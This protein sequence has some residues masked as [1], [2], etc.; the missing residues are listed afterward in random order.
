DGNIWLT[1]ADGVKSYQLTT[2]G[3]YFSPS[4]ADNG[5]IVAG[6][7]STIV[8]MD[9]AGRLLGPPVPVV[10]GDTTTG[11]PSPADKFYGPMD[12]KVSPDGKQVAYWFWEYTN[13]YSAT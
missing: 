11:G 10:G 4:Q 9:R 6:H 2:D 1:S 13:Y 5:M 8:R 3:H 7:G 12:P